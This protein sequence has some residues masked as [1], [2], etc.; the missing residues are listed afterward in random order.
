MHTLRV[1]PQRNDQWSLHGS[2]LHHV[3]TRNSRDGIWLVNFSD[4]CQQTS[5]TYNEPRELQCHPSRLQYGKPTQ[6]S[7][8][9]WTRCRALKPP[10]LHRFDLRHE[11]SKCEHNQRYLHW[12]PYPPGRGRVE[13]SDE[14]QNIFACGVVNNLI[15][16]VVKLG[17]TCSE[18]AV[19]KVKD[20]DVSAF[21]YG[22]L[23]KDS[24]KSPEVKD[25][26]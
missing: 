14:L 3:T 11:R 22:R 12:S 15:N 1:P 10:L 25:K 19:E 21:R 23:D 18:D 24:G 20:A 5:Q 16:E 6:S 9:R 8:L 4:S 17:S 26:N 7:A 2:S 13:I